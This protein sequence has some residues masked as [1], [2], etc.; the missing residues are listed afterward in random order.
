MCCQVNFLE[1]YL[2][3]LYIF[4]FGS[5]F[6][7]IGGNATVYNVRKHVDENSSAVDNRM[8]HCNKSFKKERKKTNINSM[9]R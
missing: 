9:R 2:H 5:N 1:I 8:F 4:V 3:V 6:A 7:L